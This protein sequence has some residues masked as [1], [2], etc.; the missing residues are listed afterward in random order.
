MAHTWGKLMQERKTKKGAAAAGTV[1]LGEKGE[2]WG[3]SHRA[4]PSRSHAP[5][6]KGR[7]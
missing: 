2:N 4:R 1:G 7:D 6:W 3:Q 5:R